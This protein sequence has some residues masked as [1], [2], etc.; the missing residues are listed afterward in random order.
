MTKNE[1][2]SDK[3]RQKYDI[4]LAQVKRFA[5]DEAC[6]VLNDVLVYMYDHNIVPDTDYYVIKSCKNSLYCKNSPYSRKRDKHLPFTDYDGELFEE[7]PEEDLDDMEAIDIWA[8]IEIIDCSWWEKELFKRK[9]LEDKS[10]QEIADDTGL[11]VGQVYYS[12]IKVKNALKN[13]L[14]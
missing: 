6:D 13:I 12:Y 5:G 3:I 11:T 4:W 14:K 2:L 1:E 7:T 10:F 9:V 8:A